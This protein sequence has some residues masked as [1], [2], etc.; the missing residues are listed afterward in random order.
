MKHIKRPQAAKQEETA[1]IY[2]TTKDVE[3]AFKA[4]NWN[5]QIDEREGSSALITGFTLKSGASVQ[6]FFISAAD[7]DLAIRV[8]QVLPIPAGKEDAALRVCN[9]INCE[10]RY[11]KFVVEN[12]NVGVQ[13]DVAIETANMGSVAVELLSRTLDIIDAALP[14]FKS[15]FSLVT[16]PSPFGGNGSG[17]S[18]GRW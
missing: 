1:M 14:S 13:L 16:P 10:Y 8:F 11:T 7:K 4:Q 6:L 18:S 3:A 9:K 17:N 5:Y 12:G 15:A 2:Q